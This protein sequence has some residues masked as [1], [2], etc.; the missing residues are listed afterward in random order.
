MDSGQDSCN[1]EMDLFWGI[2]AHVNLMLC[3]SGRLSV[4]SLEQGVEMRYTK[5]GI[6]AHGRKHP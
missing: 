4:Q 2:E 5:Q 3:G 1:R 6:S